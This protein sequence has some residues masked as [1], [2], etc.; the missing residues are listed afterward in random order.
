LPA[1]RFKIE[2]SRGP[3][4]AAL[5]KGKGPL[6]VIGHGAGGNMD[7][8]LLAGFSE[9]LASLDVGSLRFN[10]PF[11]EKGRKSVD[12]AGV[13]SETWEKVFDHAAGLAG[14][15]WI[16]GKSMGG[17]Y[18][19]MLAASGVSI[20]GLVF[21]GYPLHPPG[22][23]ENIRDQHLGSVKVPMLF[24]QGTEDRFARWDLLEA[25]VRRLGDLATLHR[26]EGGS[27]SFKVKGQSRGEED[28]GAELAEVA[29]KFIVDRT[30]T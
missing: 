21:L 19:S 11:S 25:S 12:S 26:V 10:F 2:T 28:I 18:A 22:K 7:H 17:R 5:T 30:S 15:I 1:K 20:S 6:L 8:P 27:H 9:Q 3:V 24:I 16:G 4:S 13:L 14:H 23:T 29:A